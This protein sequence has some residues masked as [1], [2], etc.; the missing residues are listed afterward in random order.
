M[1]AARSALIRIEVRSFTLKGKL[2]L[3]NATIWLGGAAAL[4]KRASVGDRR[5]WVAQS[6]DV[7]AIARKN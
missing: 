1:G 3:S 5:S 2:N 7:D 4:A 6:S